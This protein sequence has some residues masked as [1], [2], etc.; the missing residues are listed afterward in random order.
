MDS[1]TVVDI[2]GTGWIDGLSSA[3]FAGVLQGC[4]DLVPLLLP[5]VVGFL[6]FRK[7]WQFIKSTIKGA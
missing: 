6:A 2:T 7:A 3:S 1:G 5:T 4:M